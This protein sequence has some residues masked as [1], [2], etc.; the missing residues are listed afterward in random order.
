[1]DDSNVDSKATVKI[2]VIR[3]LASGVVWGGLVAIIY[4][5]AA[6]ILLSSQPVIARLLAVFLV[7]IMAGAVVFFMPLVF[8]MITVVMDV[9]L[10]PL[11]KLGPLQF[12]L[13]LLLPNMALFSTLVL[14]FGDPLVN[15]LWRI[16]PSFIPIDSY[17]FI[18]FYKYIVIQKTLVNNLPDKKPN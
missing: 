16:Y 18:M 8:L 9:L 4:S 3:A 5:F 15:L 17:Q 11:N 10:M 13:G 7:A 1:M 2:N 12:L 14:I 6:L